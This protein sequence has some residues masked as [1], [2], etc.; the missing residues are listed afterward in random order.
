M[1]D[2]TTNIFLDTEFIDNGS[3]IEL[4]SIGMIDD[5]NNTLYLISSEFNE[6][7]CDEWLMQN[8]VSKLGD[9]PR[10]SRE[11]IKNKVVEY[12]GDKNVRF[13]G[14]FSSYD[15]VVFCQLFGKMLDLPKGYPYYCN[16]LKQEIKRLALRTDHIDKGSLHNA[17]EDAKWNKK[18][19]EYVLNKSELI[20]IPAITIK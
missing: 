15:W 18:V 6:V 11:E 19:H 20:F 3:T 14:Y 7:N 17:L 1:N 8:V 4:I 2:N 13:W 9:E 10:F 12:I 16:D 5:N